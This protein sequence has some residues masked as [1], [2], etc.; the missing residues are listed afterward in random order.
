VISQAM[1]TGS[2]AATSVTLGA[3]PPPVQWPGAG[4]LWFG[5][6]LL[7]IGAAANLVTAIGLLRS[8]DAMARIHVMS[9]GAVAAVL[10]CLVGA[11]LVIGD[12]AALLRA[13]VAGVVLFF[14]AP[15]L[16]QALM[17]RAMAD[18]DLPLPH[19]RPT[20]RPRLEPE[21]EP[22]S[23]AEATP[24]AASAQ[25]AEASTASAEPITNHEEAR[26]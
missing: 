10:P 25:S 22:T 2:L 26:R 12:S 9:I 23:P 18:G 7:A 1:A 6:G 17:L 24:S 16:G 8:D 5:L 4:A 3:A 21:A 14:A 13:G 11:A 15:F 20:L 19:E